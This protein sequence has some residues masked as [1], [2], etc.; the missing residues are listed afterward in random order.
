MYRIKTGSRAAIPSH[1]TTL[2]RASLG[3]GVVDE[4]TPVAPILESVEKIEPVTNL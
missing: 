2:R 4:I 1:R 3:R